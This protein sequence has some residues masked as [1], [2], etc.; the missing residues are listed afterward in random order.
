MLCNSEHARSLKNCIP[1]SHILRIKRIYSTKE[2]FDNHSKELKEKFLKQG[3]DQKLVHEELEK[4]DQLIRDDL[5]REKYREQQDPKPIPLILTFNRFLRSFTAFVRKNWNI[6]QT[7]KH[8]RKLLQE[9]AVTTFKRNKNLKQ[10]N[11]G[12]RIESSKV[13]N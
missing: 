11:G 1:Q 5:L 7:N 8:L 4:V 2:D 10:I 9:H 13:K 12:K 6:L 3:Y